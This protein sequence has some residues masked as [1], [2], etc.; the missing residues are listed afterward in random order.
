M[1]FGFLKTEAFCN[2]DLL[3]PCPS[4]LPAVLECRLPAL[5]RKFDIAVNL[6]VT[7]FIRFLNSSKHQVPPC[8]VM[9]KSLKSDVVPGR[10]T[11]KTE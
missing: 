5:E 7:I 3:A 6:H 10:E 4:L 1:L 9:G 2:E 11:L 8:W